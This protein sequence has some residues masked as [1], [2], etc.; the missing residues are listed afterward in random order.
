M[1]TY[2]PKLAPSILAAA[3]AAASSAAV[4]D[5]FKGR[6]VNAA[7]AP[8]ANAVVEI[9]DGARVTTN[10]NGEFSIRHDG[11]HADLHVIADGYAHLTVDADSSKTNNFTLYRSSIEEIHVTGLPLHISNLESTVPVTVLDEQAVR[12][13]QA[14]TLGDTLKNELGVHSTYYGPVASSPIIR[15]LDGPR[16]LIAQNGLDVGDVSR[17]GPDHIVSTESATTERIEIL[18]GP[19]TLFYGSGA[20]GGVVNVID[21]RVPESNDFEGAVQFA[22]RTASDENEAAF[23]VTGGAGN[24]ALH[25]DAFWRDSSDLEIPENPELEHDEH[26]EDEHDH[27]DDH[28][29]EDHDEH[30][31]FG[32]VLENSAAEAKGFNVGASYLLDNG[33]VG[34]S[35]GRTERLNG[36]PGH[37]HG[38]ELVQSDMEQ[39]RIQLIANAQLD[40][41][42]FSEVSAK[43]GRTDYEHK[44]QEGTEV[45]TVFTTEL[46]EARFELTFNEVNGWRGALL[47]D[48]KQRDV[49]S[50]GEEAFAP[51]AGTDSFALA[52][53][54]EKH[55][56]DFLWQLGVRAESVRLSADPFELHIEHHDEEGHDDGHDDH[57][58]HEEESIV[59]FD[60]QSFTP[61][62]WSAGFVW[63]YEQGYNLGLSL[64]HAQRAPVT[65]ELY[66]AGPHIGTGSYELGTQFEAHEENG[67]VHI[68]L[69]ETDIELERSNNIELTWRK[70]EGDLGL[71][72]N[73]FYNRINDYYY[74][75][76]TGLFMESGHEHEEEHHDEDMH[77]EHEEGH[78]E[79]EDLLP[80]YNYRQADV[81]LLGL[82]TMATYQINDSFSTSVQFDAIKGELVGGGNLPRI[83]PMRLGGELNYEQGPWN[84]SVSAMHYFEQDNV[85]AYE[86][87]TE[88]YTM[89]DMKAEYQVPMQS[90]DLRIALKA[91]NLLDEA[92]RVHTSYLKDQTLLPG[93]GIDLSVRAYF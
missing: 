28:D 25:A 92:A 73:V 35:V 76:N 55:F 66:S 33:Y 24:I 8:V 59:H 86:T 84:A 44:E 67:E 27:D 18:R 89:V 11:S 37:S 10:A 5:D 7:G 91:T 4:A 85:A 45:G 52:L 31:E 13:K 16:V 19:A 75:E 63:D 83:P 79:H 1:K 30:D 41:K 74:A 23:S 69:H 82:E 68:D 81:E 32:G 3:V 65:A 9:I 70:F 12:D 17:T 49:S 21:N 14:A 72:V 26:H 77:D 61:V 39:D 42:V 34:V 56:G 54:E 40:G 36:V 50:E 60:R 20:I 71:I 93:R 80:I 87:H 64:S 78:E 38:D 6:L 90:T 53:I 2:F 62:S 47:A 58:E 51:S 22:H 46:T 88:G 43:L 48:V 57:D 15:G 29:H